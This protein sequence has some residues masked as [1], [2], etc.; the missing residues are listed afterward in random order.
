[1]CAT[2]RGRRPVRHDAAGLTARWRGRTVVPAEWLAR[3]LDRR[4]RRP[5]GVR[6]ARRPAPTCRA[7]GTATS[8]GSCLASTGSVLLCLG[9]YG[10][11]PHVE[12]PRVRATVA[13]K[14]VVLAGRTGTG[15]CCMTPSTPS[16]RSEPCSPGTPPMPP[17]CTAGPRLAAGLSR[18]GG[19]DGT[20]QRSDHRLRLAT[21]PAGRQED[22][23]LEPPSPVPT[24]TAGR[25]LNGIS[26]IRGYSRTNSNRSISSARQPSTC[27]EST[28]GCA[29]SSTSPT[30][31]PGT[32]DPAR[33]AREP[34]VRRI[35][36][37]RRDQQ[38]PATGSRGAVTSSGAAAGDPESPWCS[39]T[40]R[41][42]TICANGWATP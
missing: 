4:H 23:M 29:T 40:R 10:Q 37:Q 38:L 11:T 3:I 36:Q 12:E 41:P 6:Y 22:K 39:S 26:E 8:S 18:R 24:S 19:S 16:T 34:A 25:R 27:W 35:H 21:R 5:G 13:A 17:D 1:M 28:D 20:G 2:R 31:T 30:T 42:K 15:S 33:S 32:A 7:A 9:I 14:P